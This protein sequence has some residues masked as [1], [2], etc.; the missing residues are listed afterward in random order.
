ME[1]CMLMMF[2]FFLQEVP[3]SCRTR[4]MWAAGV[5]YI[6]FPPYLLQLPKKGSLSSLGMWHQTTF[7]CHTCFTCFAF[8]FSAHTP[9]SMPCDLSVCLASVC[10][11]LILCSSSSLSHNYYPSFSPHLPH[12]SDP[13]MSQEVTKTPPALL[14]GF[15]FFPIFLSLCHALPLLLYHWNS[16]SLFFFISGSVCLWLLL[17]AHTFHIKTLLPNP[18]KFELLNVSVLF[19]KQKYV[20]RCCVPEVSVKVA[21]ACTCE[22][23]WTSHAYTGGM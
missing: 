21:C 10:P 14:S 11:Y 9:P 1:L 15:P 13:S 8:L 20:P 19:P 23:C 7:L 17:H 12:L 4:S 5:S 3:A 6:A 18:F 16:V 2:H 22:M